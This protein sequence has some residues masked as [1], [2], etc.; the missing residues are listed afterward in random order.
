M[1]LVGCVVMSNVTDC[2]EI[3]IHMNFIYPWFNKME[4]RPL[5]Q[6][7]PDHAH[8]DIIT[9]EETKGSSYTRVK[10]NIIYRR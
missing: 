3:Q 2:N 10:S 1:L 4:I 6:T 9:G 8:S 5:A 7:R